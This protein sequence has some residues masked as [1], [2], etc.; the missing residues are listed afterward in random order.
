MIAAIRAGALSPA[1]L[2]LPRISPSQG[3]RR[4]VAITLLVS[5]L[6]LT[7]LVAA[8]NLVVLGGG[9]G[10]ITASVSEVPKAQVAI[11][12]GALVHD[13]GRMSDML[14]ARVGQ[15]YALYEA[16]K[17]DRILVSGDHGTWE[18]DEPDTMRKALVGMGV[19]PRV[20]FE[21]HA[22]FDTWSTM[23]RA[24][25]I[26]GVSSAVVVTQGFHMRRALYMAEQAGVP[27]TGLTADTQ[28][29]GANG[30]RGSVREIFARVK[31]VWEVQTGGKVMG[32][33]AI[34]ITGDG[35]A[36]WGPVPPEGTPPAGSPGR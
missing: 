17:V 31:G 15:A 12:P 35:R 2:R 27:A 26:F 23:V 32:G 16:G 5:A 24:R 30:L 19:P 28:E 20:I 29:W 25:E 11:V 21:D 14:A 18:Y 3:L 4:A 9:S 6:L 36:S 1:S 22:G 7:A 33:P 10:Q 8:A 13:D 34:P